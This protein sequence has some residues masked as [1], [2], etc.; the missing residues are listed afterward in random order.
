MDYL[1][2]NYIKISNE[3]ILRDLILKYTKMNCIFIYVKLN[4]FREMIII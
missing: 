2:S 4:E 3:S 1:I